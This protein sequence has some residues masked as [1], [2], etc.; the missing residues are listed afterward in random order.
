MDSKNQKWI[1]LSIL[2]LVWGSSFILMKKAL[3]GLTPIQLGALRILIAS[4]FYYW[5]DLK[6]LRKSKE[7]IGNILLIR[8]F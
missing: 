2:A 1:H 8:L 7:N 5:L 4:I 3:I 6:A